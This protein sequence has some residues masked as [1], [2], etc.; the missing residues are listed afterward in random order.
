MHTGRFPPPPP[1]KKKKIFSI[2]MGVNNNNKK[3]QSEHSSKGWKILRIFSL[4]FHSSYKLKDS[5][6]HI[7]QLRALL[8]RPHNKVQISFRFVCQ[9]V[10]F[11]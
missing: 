5:L 7:L 2:P 9:N 11:E 3:R 1:Q 6:K 8:P 4:R 10:A